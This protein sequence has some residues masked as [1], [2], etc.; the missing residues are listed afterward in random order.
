VVEPNAVGVARLG[1]PPLARAG[2]LATDAVQDSAVVVGGGPDD[3]AQFLCLT[4]EA[5]TEPRVDA[6]GE[7]R[8]RGLQPRVDA[9]SQSLLQ[10]FFELGA[11]AGEPPPWMP[12]ERGANT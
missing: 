12:C 6:L 3:L 9:S 1:L 7:A 10:A 4:P 8:L 5:M 2:E 11:H